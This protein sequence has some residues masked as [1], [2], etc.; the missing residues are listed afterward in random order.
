MHSLEIIEGFK[1]A[2][3]IVNVPK[4]YEP[5]DKNAVLFLHTLKGGGSQMAVDKLIPFIKAMGMNV[6]IVS[7]EDGFYRQRFM[8]D[9]G[10]VVVIHPDLYITD[11]YTSFMR[12]AFDFILFN[13]CCGGLLYYYIDTDIKVYWWV[14]EDMAVFETNAC[15][16]FFAPEIISDNVFFLTPWKKFA[17]EFREKYHKD[18]DILTIGYEK[19][20]DEEVEGSQ[21]LEKMFRFLIPGS[22]E[23][24]K[25]FQD[26]LIAATKLPGFMLDMCQ[27][28]FVGYVA[29]EPLFNKFAEI[30]AK[31]PYIK[32]L[33]PVEASELEK[34]Y[35]VSD[36]VVVPS[37][38]DIGP[39]TAVEALRLGKCLIISDVT[40][41]SQYIT[42]GEDGFKVGAE[43][44]DAI[45]GC[46][47]VLLTDRDKKDVVARNGQALFDRCFSMDVMKADVERIWGNG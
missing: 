16:Q 26:A 20:R 8:D 5:L 24:R 11:S 4:D 10:A 21:N 46:Y 13:S 32:V 38:L 41:M 31:L 45:A 28:I 18:I 27:F 3:N 44:V 7:V 34:L 17:K 40:G 6:F 35:R 22:Y 29:E 47:K 2:D 25:G 30:A 36:V 12:T 19:A 39:L 14:H 37:L 9:Y 1:V 33:G 42:D 23:V 15:K 43:D